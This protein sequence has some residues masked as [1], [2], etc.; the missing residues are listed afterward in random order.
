M[1]NTS[2]APK[3]TLNSILFASAPVLE[4][5]EEG[6]T[7]SKEVLAKHKEGVQDHI[8]TVST[9]LAQY[10]VEKQTDTSLIAKILAATAKAI[11]AAVQFQKEEAERQEKAREEARQKAQA[12]RERMAEEARKHAEEEGKKMLQILL[13]NG[14]DLAVAQAA[15]AAGAAKL[16][17]AASNTNSTYNR[18]TVKVGGKEYD[19]PEKGNMSQELKDL[20]AESNLDREA[21]IEK[22]R[23]DAPEA[24][25]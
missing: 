8:N 17:T 3:V 12:E 7:H 15:V 11:P 6:Q 19:M 2:K 13:D 25:K 4:A 16:K 21:F 24:A 5:P 14:V 23:V 10:F 1:A 18:V 9:N 20:V 22:Y